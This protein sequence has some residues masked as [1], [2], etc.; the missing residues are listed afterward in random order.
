MKRDRYFQTKHRDEIL[1]RYNHRCANCGSTDDLEIHHIVPVSLGGRDVI[2][3]LVPLCSSCHKA[4]HTGRNVTE[5]RKATGRLRGGRKRLVNQEVFDDA[6]EKYVTGR[7]GKKKLCLLTG[8]KS[9]NIYPK[10][11]PA[12]QEAMNR[13]GISCIKNTVDIVAV[14][15][16][17]RDGAYVGFVEYKD[18][19]VEDIYYHDTGLNDVEYCKRQM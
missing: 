5:I 15:S 10:K 6:F 18:G 9:T 7:I 12:Y 2:E 1:E 19:R 13:H 3:N 4:A 14:N 8:R 16:D 17:L 11:W